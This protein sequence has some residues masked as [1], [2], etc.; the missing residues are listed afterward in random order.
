MYIRLLGTAAGG[1]FPQWN[2]NCCQCRGVRQGTKQS[3]ARTQSSVALSADGLHWFLLNVSPDIR[4]QIEAFP[5]LSPPAGE[6]RHSPIVAIFLTDAD[7]DHT[8]GLLVLRE[9]LRRTIYATP[10]VRHALT[11]GLRLLPA[12]ACYCAV[13]WY[14]P[15]MALT[16]LAYADGTPSGLRYT[17]CR[18]RGH[19]PRYM[20]TQAT[21]GPD[22]RVGYYFIDAQS[23]GRFLYLPGLASLAEESIAQFLTQCDLLLVDG[24]FW[25][26]Q[27]MIMTQTGT[28]SATAMGHLPIGGPTGSLPLL[29]A[30]PIKHRVY[31]HINNTNPILIEDTPEH[32]T[33]KAAGVEIGYDGMEFR[34]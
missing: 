12:L 14:A 3:H 31:I 8:L 9:G 7:L 26:E 4:Q 33:V 32:A 29:A 13:D 27:E 18:L 19:P 21:P 24:T 28:K 2:C 30:L 1:G 23:G 16:S 25:N 10:G 34:L 11:E 17:A 20:G 22:D 15:A 6:T 5:P